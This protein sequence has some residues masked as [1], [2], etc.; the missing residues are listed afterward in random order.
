MDLDSQ[1][2]VRHVYLGGVRIA[3]PTTTTG[4]SLSGIDVSSGTYDGSKI[5]HAFLQISNDE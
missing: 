3:S 2:T 5:M 1:A 4:V